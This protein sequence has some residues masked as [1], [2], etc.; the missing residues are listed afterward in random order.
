MGNIA[1]ENRA[2]AR[3]TSSSLL[4]GT[5]PPKTLE[6]LVSSI[7]ARPIADKLIARYFGHNASVWR[8]L[9]VTALWMI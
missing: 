4:R 7:P 2:T 8:K 6:R 9:K 5:T 3:S 1:N